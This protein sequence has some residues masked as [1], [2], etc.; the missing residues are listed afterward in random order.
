[1]KS[2]AEKRAVQRI[3]IEGPIHLEQGCGITRDISLSGVYFVSDQ[4][5]SEGVRFRF[6]IE[7]EYAIPGRPIHIDCLAQVLRV[8]PLG[9]QSGIA[10]RIDDFTS[11]QPN[12][13][14]G[15]TIVPETKNL[16]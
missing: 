11:L 15:L 12:R 8:E 14:P 5:F 6:T 4:D 1:V 9:A 7:L 10:A 16:Q 3:E 2:A 13:K